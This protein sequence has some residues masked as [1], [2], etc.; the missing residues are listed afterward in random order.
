MVL[1]AWRNYTDFVFEKLIQINLKNGIRKEE[2]FEEISE[3]SELNIQSESSSEDEQSDENLKEENK[4][5]QIL[6]T[7]MNE[8]VNPLYLS[9]KN[10]GK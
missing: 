4:Q 6:H 8:I 10:L 5:F 9:P 2:K 3:Y 1:Y 7:S